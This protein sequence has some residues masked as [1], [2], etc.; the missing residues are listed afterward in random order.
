MNRFIRQTC[1]ASVSA[2]VLSVT[3]FASAQQAPSNSGST[4]TTPPVLVTPGGST[5]V[6]VPPP[7][8]GTTTTTAATMTPPAPMA[9]VPVTET[10]S[11]IN[12]PLLLTGALVLGGTYGASA[13][14]SGTSGR[15]SDKSHLAVP[16]V[17]PWLDLA[18]RDT[19]VR[20]SRNEGL[21][22]ALLIADGVGQGLGAIALISAFFVP[23]KTVRHFYVLG[24]EKIH[25]APTRVGTGYGLGGGGTF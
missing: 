11:P 5:T 8:V 6:I 12:R 2:L 23:E 4:G 20:P 13:I 3:A 10:K 25:V 21:N 14:I 22:K 19:D 17:G 1:A 24:N 16:M 7:A 18:N 15:P 9:D